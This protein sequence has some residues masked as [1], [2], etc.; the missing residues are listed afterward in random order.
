LHQRVKTTHDTAE[1]DTSADGRRR[2]RVLKYVAAMS[3]G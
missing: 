3:R 2:E 1:V